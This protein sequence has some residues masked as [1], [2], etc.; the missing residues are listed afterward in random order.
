MITS[1]QRWRTVSVLLD[2]KILSVLSKMIFLT[3]LPHI[4]LSLGKSVWRLCLKLQRTIIPAHILSYAETD[5]EKDVRKVL[6]TTEENLVRKHYALIELCELLGESKA[7]YERIHPTTQK[8]KAKKPKHSGTELFPAPVPKPL[9]YLDVAAQHLGKSRGTI[10]KY[11]SIYKKLIQGHPQEFAELKQCDHPILAKVEDL[12]ELAQS[13]DIEALTRLL[14]GLGLTP[15]DRKSKPCTLQEAQK[16]LEQ[17]RARA[18]QG[19]S[20]GATSTTPPG[21]SSGHASNQSADN[22]GVP[23]ETTVDPT[24]QQDSG[25]DRPEMAQDA[26]QHQQ[27]YCQELCM[28]GSRGVLFNPNAILKSRT[29]H[30]LRQVMRSA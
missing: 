7:L 10:W 25:T 28:E 6:A 5:S 12:L 14:C 20:S 23:G 4:V 9:A 11:L 29:V 24:S 8:G 26:P 13:D 16:R 18:G 21:P 30:N 27:S 19:P 17:Y 3:M 1:S 2:Y 15:D 22:G